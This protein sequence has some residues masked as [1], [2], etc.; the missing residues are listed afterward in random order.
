MTRVRSSI[1]QEA[2][3]FMK[4]AKEK[5]LDSDKMRSFSAF[6]GFGEKAPF[7]FILAPSKLVKRLQDNFVF[8]YLNYILVTAVVLALTLLATL[9]SPKTLILLGVLAVVW[10]AVLKVTTAD[11]FKLFGITF[12]RKE[13]SAIM[14]IIT[15]GVI[16][17]FFESVFLISI[18]SS[19]FL[20]LVHAW[21]RDAEEVMTAENSKEKPLEPD[22]EFQ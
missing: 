21:T 16:F 19:A 13:V 1:P 12:T 22:A 8:F 9:M 4:T 18:C 11:G 14:M 5:V 3:D 17:Y 10:F 2:K 7:G 20:V 6:F 15:G